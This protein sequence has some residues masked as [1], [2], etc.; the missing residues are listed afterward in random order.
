[1]SKLLSQLNSENLCHFFILPMIGLN[2]AKFGKQ[3]VDARLHVTDPVVRVALTAPVTLPGFTGKVYK[4]T[5]YNGMVLTY[6][7]IHPVYLPDIQKF[8]AGLYSKMSDGVKHLIKEKSGLFW[9]LGD[10]VKGNEKMSDGR[11]LALYK[12]KSLRMELAELLGYKSWRDPMLDGEL[13]TAPK[14]TW[15]FDEPYAVGAL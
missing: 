14:E 2:K 8:R 15:F 10:D 3:F 5:R 6:Y 9:K 1:M 11:L 12:D 13:L 7:A 4:V